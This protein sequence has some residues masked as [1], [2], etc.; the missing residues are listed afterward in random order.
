MGLKSLIKN[1]VIFCIIVFA[2]AIMVS[3]N[4][5]RKCRNRGGGLYHYFSRRCDNIIK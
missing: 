5:I 2:L 3:I 1:I 4:E